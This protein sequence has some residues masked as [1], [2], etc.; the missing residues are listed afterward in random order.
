MLAPFGGIAAEFTHDFGEPVIMAQVLGECYFLDVG[1]GSAQ[2]IDLS[3]DS[4]IVI[5]CGP[6]Y[7]VL[8]ELL[9]RRLGKRR[10]AAVIL[11]HNHADHIGGHL[12]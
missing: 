5:D 2:V 7:P 10:I 12:A 1:L 4:A 8:G 6:S 11:S 9:Q 3:D